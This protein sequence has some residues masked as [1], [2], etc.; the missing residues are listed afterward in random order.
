MPNRLT[1]IRLSKRE[2]CIF[3]IAIGVIIMGMA[4]NFIFEHLFERWGLLNNEI[5]AKRAKFNKEIR[6]LENRNSVISEY[7][8]YARGY[9]NSSRVLSYI[10]KS[11]GSLN[12]KTSNIKPGQTADKVFYQEY[13]IELQI[14]GRFPEIIEFL[15]GISKLPCFV[16]I[17][18]FD[19]RRDQESLYL[20]KGT[21]ILSKII[22]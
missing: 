6:L 1:Y 5:I 15:S 14:E 3:I 13:F 16:T 2:K 8:N 18:K 9:K 7:N 11:A 19:F 22:I 4:Y 10:E 12:I 21:V 17:K 20:L